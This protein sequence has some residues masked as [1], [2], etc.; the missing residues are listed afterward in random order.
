M[1]LGGIVSRVE[2]VGGYVNLWSQRARAWKAAF[3]KV[4]SAAHGFKASCVPTPDLRNQN[5]WK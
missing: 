5:L 4:W 3:F 2:L 1:T